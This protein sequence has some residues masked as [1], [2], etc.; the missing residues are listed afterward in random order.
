MLHV[1]AS[2]RVHA[3][4][5]S[6]VRVQLPRIK[7]P[8]ERTAGYRAFHLQIIAGNILSMVKQP[9]MNHTKLQTGL[10]NM[11]PAN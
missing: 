6:R 4:R 10:Y 3:V 7:N 9:M 11:H 1:Q 2:H 8:A 5:W